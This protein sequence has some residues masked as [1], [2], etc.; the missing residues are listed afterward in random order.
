VPALGLI[1]AQAGAA[2]LSSVADYVQ[3][4]ARLSHGEAVGALSLLW[5]R[6]PRPDNHAASKE[7]SRMRSLGH[8][9]DEATHDWYIHVYRVSE[10]EGPA[11]LRSMLMAARLFHS[12][13]HEF[14]PEAQ[15]LR[16]AEIGAG[17]TA[18]LGQIAGIRLA[19]MEHSAAEEHA[20]PAA[21]DPM[22]RW[23]VGHQ[24]FVAL[25]Q[26]IILALQEFEAAA[27]TPD[28]QPMR[29]ALALA[30]DLLMASATAF[31]FTAD[32]APTVYHDIVRPS[33]MGPEVGEGFSGL[34]SV[35][36]RRLVAVLVRVRP[37]L[38]QAAVRFVA[39]H[40]RLTLALNHVYG[41]HKFVCARFGGAEQPRLL[42]P[43]SSPLSGVEQLDRYQRARVE[44]LRPPSG[45]DPIILS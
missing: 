13:M 22:W 21:L 8:L 41:D 18:L 17:L 19:S 37:L 35:D 11:F 1:R 39:E 23:V 28:E 36:H 38:G 4:A 31:R 3:R 26:G 32:F 7:P 15:A 9:A 45:V 2:L 44:L 27:A 16:Y 30:A 24:I 6:L 5:H 42:C 34:L 33:M 40:E 12:E 25:T 10:P 20:A 43:R 14:Y 29:D